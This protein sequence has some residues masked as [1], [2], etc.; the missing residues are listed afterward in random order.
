MVYN[1][2]TRQNIIRKDMDNQI[3]WILFAIPSILIAS[4]AHEYAH[5]YTAYKLGDV[6]AK[7]SGRLTLNPLAHIDPIGVVMMA[8]ARIGWSKPVPINEYNFKNPVIGT[9]L[10]SFAGP[11]ANLILAFAASLILRLFPYTTVT[12]ALSTETSYVI[13][14]ILVFIMV[15]ISLAVFNLLPVPPLDGH[16]IVRAFLPAKLRY[17]WESL[18]RYGMWILV[19]LFLPISP[20][21]LITSAFLSFSTQLLLKL[22]L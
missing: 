10:T 18:D 4:T 12:S 3:Q 7:A 11:S 15:N 6:T 9:A 16:K 8:I 20:L 14:I 17:T 21:Y 5:A 19:A 1:S 2:K 22:L 13:T